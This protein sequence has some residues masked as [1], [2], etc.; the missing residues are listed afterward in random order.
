MT[1]TV[2]VGSSLRG[3]TSWRERREGVGYSAGT[4]PRACEAR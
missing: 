4:R 2:A 3:L 1:A